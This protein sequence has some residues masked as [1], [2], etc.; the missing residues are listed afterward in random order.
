MEEKYTWNLTDIFKSEED[1]KNSKQNLKDILEKINQYK[2]KL[3]CA[4]NIFECY[5][6]YEE[7]YQI[8]ERLYAFGMLKYHQDMSNQESIKLFKEA[9]NIEANFS[10]NTSFIVPEISEIDEETLKS[11]I[12]KKEYC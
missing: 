8:L 1:F 11:I 10:L 9:E 6:L 3:N 7:A 2:G 12:D 4:E 5:S